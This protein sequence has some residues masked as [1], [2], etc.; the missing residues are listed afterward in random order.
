MVVFLFLADLI[1]A[2]RLATAGEKIKALES[3]LEKLKIETSS[4]EEKIAHS[5]SIAGIIR[6]AEGLGFTDSPT[7]FYLREEIPMAMR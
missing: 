1:I 4:L 2:N 5:G 3:E 6:R 7:V